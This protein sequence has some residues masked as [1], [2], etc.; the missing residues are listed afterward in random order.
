MTVYYEFFNP[1]DDKKITVGFEAFSPSGDVDGTINQWMQHH[2]YMRDFTVE[3]NNNILKYNVAYVSDSLYTENGKIKSLSIPKTDDN[4]NV[5]EVGFYYVY[6]FDATFKK[7]INVI[8][9]TYNYDLRVQLTI[10][11]ILNMS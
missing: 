10:I 9:H 3:L 11:T 5:N 7:G 6:H 8:K 4:T 1:N 2:P